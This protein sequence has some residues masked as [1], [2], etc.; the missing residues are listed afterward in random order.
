MIKVL[1]FLMK[2]LRNLKPNYKVLIVFITILGTSHNS[3][4]FG[5]QSDY[6]QY[7]K[8]GIEEYKLIK[9][10]RN[11]EAKNKGFG[12]MDALDC[13]EPNFSFESKVS[14]YP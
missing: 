4:V 14:S 9:I 3:R 13:E 6:E 5:T 11:A 10:G 2:Y 7:E 1:F 8:T 12:S